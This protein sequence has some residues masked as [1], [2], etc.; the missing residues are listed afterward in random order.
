MADDEKSKKTLPLV[1]GVK[2]SLVEELLAA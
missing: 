1:E 2:Q